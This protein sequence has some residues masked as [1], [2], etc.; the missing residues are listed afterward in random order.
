VILGPLSPVRWVR[1]VVRLLLAIVTLLFL[2]F[3]VTFVQVYS[4]SQNDGAREAEAIVV[5]GAAQYDGRPS[6]VL[7][8]RLDHAYELWKEE[9]A[10][11]IVVTGGRK[12]GD[13]FTEADASY[14][15]LR[16]QGV[17]DE[18]ILREESGR[19]TWEQLAGSARFLED[20]SIDEVLLVTD[21]YHA[22]R[23]EAV[24]EELGLDAS[25]SPTDAG[26]S[27]MGAFK[28]LLR[29]SAAVSIGRIIGYGRL[30]RLDQIRHNGNG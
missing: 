10:P 19:N 13:R 12:E 18:A 27:T 17:P 6:P 5:L 24:A 7:Q 23:V 14:R 30:V 15:Y 21:D 16:N 4:A 29:E 3:A 22:F 8:H 11:I 28:A 20:R 9:F 25:V 2:Y 26:L 1:V